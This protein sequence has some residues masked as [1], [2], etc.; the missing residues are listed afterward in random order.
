MQWVICAAVCF[1]GYVHRNWHFNSSISGGYFPKLWAY[2]PKYWIK[3]YE[4]FITL[5]HRWVRWAPAL[6]YEGCENIGHPRNCML[7]GLL[8]MLL[9]P[10][11]HGVPGRPSSWLPKLQ[12]EAGNQKDVNILQFITITIEL[13]TFICRY[14]VSIVCTPACFHLN[15]MDPI[16]RFVPRNKCFPWSLFRNLNWTWSNPEW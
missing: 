1:L 7:Q 6:T 8:R 11:L 9:H 15:Y 4:T 3:Y 14:I 13:V 2:Y 16:I 10:I 12:S 5:C